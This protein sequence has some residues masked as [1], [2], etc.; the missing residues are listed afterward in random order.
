M[1]KLNPMILIVDDEPYILRSLSFVLKRAGMNILEARNGHDAIETVR[2]E[3]PVLV[4][5]DIMMPEK[6]GYEV[7]REIKSD[8]NLENVYVVLLSAKGQDIDRKL[9]LESG[10]DEYITKPFSPSK[11]VEKA[12]AILEKADAN[13]EEEDAS[14]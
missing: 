5:L 7:C 1:R 4:F 11:I 9:G 2:R 13:A 3:R 8:K 10:A 14:K 6:N 12:R